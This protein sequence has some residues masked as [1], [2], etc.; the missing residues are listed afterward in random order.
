MAATATDEDRASAGTRFGQ[1][2]L[3]HLLMYDPSSRISARAATAHP[4][5]AD[6]HPQY[7]SF[8]NNGNGNGTQTFL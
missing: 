5:F 2:L 6:L 1:D 8:C 4:W 7:A 3:S